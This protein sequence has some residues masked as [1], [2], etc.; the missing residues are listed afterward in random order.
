MSLLLKELLESRH[1]SHI[2]PLFFYISNVI[3][4]YLKFPLSNHLILFFDTEIIGF[5]LFAEK[6]TF[7]TLIAIV[8]SK[9]PVTIS[10][11]SMIS[12]TE[13]SVRG[14]VSMYLAVV[15]L[16]YINV[17]FL[18]EGL[19]WPGGGGSSRIY[20]YIFST[21]YIYVHDF[22]LSMSV[23]YVERSGGGGGGSLSFD[24]SMG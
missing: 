18:T 2:D 7:N 17:I 4:S 16:F 14:V 1:V 3:K 13:D 11:L 22:S 23:S 12:L 8:I 21:L 9:K 15:F 5:Q 10:I 19:A 20:D 6:K 24:T